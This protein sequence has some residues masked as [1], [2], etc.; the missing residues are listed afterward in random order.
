MNLI[1]VFPITRRHRSGL[2]RTS[3]PR[4]SWIVTNRHGPSCSEDVRV[5]GSDR[6]KSMFCRGFK[7]DGHIRSTPSRYFRPHNILPS[8]KLSQRFELQS[9]Q[10]SH[11]KSQ[12]DNFILGS[13]SDG[14]S[15]SSWSSS[16][17]SSSVDFFIASRLDSNRFNAGIAWIIL[18]ISRNSHQNVR[19]NWSTDC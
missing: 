17:L 2:R 8:D 1:N 12:G 9:P 6:K 16:I 18:S 19:T 4:Q 5:E 13:I 10:S 3:A 15:P 14:K 11:M 7:N